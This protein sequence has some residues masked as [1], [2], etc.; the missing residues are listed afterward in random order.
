M[1]LAVPKEIY[2]LEK[3][4]MLNAEAVRHLTELGHEVFIQS[5]AAVKVNISDAEYV[6]SGGKIVTAAKNLYELAEMVVKVKAPL[7]EEFSLM[8]NL[9]LF[10]MFHSDQNS[11]H[12]YYAGKQNLTV[13]EM[14][15]IRDEKNRR[16]ID[17][18]AITGKAGVYYALQHSQKMPEEMKAI[19]LGYGNVSSGALDACS[20]LGIQFKIIRKSEFK[21]LPQY[22]KEADILINGI[23][24]P[25]SRRLKKEYLVTR[26]DIQNSR[27]EMIILDL[28]VDFPNPIETVHPTTYSQPYYFEEGRVHISL[29]GYPGLFPVTSTHIYSQQIEPLALLIAT[30]GGLSSIEKNGDLGMAIK[31]AIIHPKKSDW[32]KYKPLEVPPGSKIE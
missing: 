4:V 26:E 24:W 23:A 18:T 14:E 9:I 3:R 15:S 27:E 12:L 32:E 31:K 7:P 1:R 19:I 5:G 16:L 25:E 30:N 22:L 17:Q 11:S 6:A 21:H 2:P 10:C 28:S 8:Q 20:R 29:Y 13:V